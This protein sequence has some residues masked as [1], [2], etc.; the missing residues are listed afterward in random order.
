MILITIDTL[1]SALVKTLEIFSIYL[2][3]KQTNDRL[4]GPYTHLLCCI[5][6][7]ERN[8]TKK[9]ETKVEFYLSKKKSLCLPQQKIFLL[10]YARI[11]L[12]LKK[13]MKFRELNRIELTQFFIVMK[14]F[15]QF[16]LD[17]NKKFGN[18]E[19]TLI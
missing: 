8:M 15:A 2:A 12:S 18:H 14:F 6:K 11:G 1:N 10:V 16:S 4:H 3:R 7:K 17:N 9:N 13:W 5:K 19:K